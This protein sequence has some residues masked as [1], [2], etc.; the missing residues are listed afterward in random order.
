MVIL[1]V[2]HNRNKANKKFIF[3][4][5]FIGKLL[6]A[7]KAGGGINSLDDAKEILKNGA[8]K[9]IINSNLVKGNLT[10]KLAHE[11]GRQCI[12]GSIDFKKI[13]KKYAIFINNGK[14]KIKDMI[15][16]YIKN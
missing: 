5:I 14:D 12:V 8:D 1:N 15:D 4:Q 7:H 2:S 3:H 11:F 10:K 6:Y 9:I 16:Y 13:E